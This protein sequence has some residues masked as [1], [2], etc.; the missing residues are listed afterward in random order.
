MFDDGWKSFFMCYTFMCYKFLCSLE[1]TIKTPPQR[2][3]LQHLKIVLFRTL[4]LTV[5][6]CVCVC[7]GGGR[8]D[9]FQQRR[10]ARSRP[11]EKETLNIC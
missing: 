5:F 3:L 6:R 8:K 10:Q 7:V 4:A 2:T 9:E 1:E 11:V